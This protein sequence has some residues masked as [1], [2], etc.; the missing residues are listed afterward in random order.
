MLRNGY[1]VAATDYP[2][3]GTG[4]VH[5]FLDG[6][7]EGRAVLDS[8][9]AAAAIPEAMTARHYALWGHSQ[10]GQA[11]LFAGSLAASYTPELRLAGVAAAAPATDLATLFRDDLG[12]AGGNNLTALTLWAWARFY[13]ANYSSVVQPAATPAIEAVANSCIDSLIK[14]PS[15]R[16]ADATLASTFLSVPDMTSIEPWR[17]LIKRNSVQ[18]LPPTVPVFL[19]QGGADVIVRPAVTYSFAQ[20][21]CAGGSR[22]QLAVVPGTGHSWIAMRTASAAVNWMG[23]RFKGAL[24]PNDCSQLPQLT[25]GATWSN[26]VQPQRGE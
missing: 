1:V 24:A 25:A 7:S 26:P 15:K 17:S 8:V 11:V 23:D 22:L 13:G 6:A 2:G 19:A 20:R 10:G 12:T 21:L 5:P 9:R 3:L 14:R 4:R 18:P 16:R